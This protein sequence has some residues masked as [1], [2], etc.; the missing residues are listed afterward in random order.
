MTKIKLRLALGRPTGAD[1]A[2]RLGIAFG[3][4]DK[5]ETLFD[6]SDG[7]E[8]I[9]FIGVGIIEDLQ[10]VIST[11]EEGACFLKGNAVLL[12]IRAALGFMSPAARRGTI[13]SGISGTQEPTPIMRFRPRELQLHGSVRVVAPRFER[14]RCRQEIGIVP[15]PAPYSARH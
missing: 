11:G 5:Y 8:P 13:F 12:S 2:N 14:S 10:V 9:F 7:D 1:E 3:V 4:H 15:A 6:R